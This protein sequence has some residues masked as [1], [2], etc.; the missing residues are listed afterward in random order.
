MINNKKISPK[1]NRIT[2]ISN[3]TKVNLTIGNTSVPAYLG[4]STAA[5][6]LYKQL[7]FKTQVSAG[8]V[9]FCGKFSGLPYLEDE[10]QG[11][12]FAGDICYDPN[13]DWLAV[14]TGGDNAKPHLKEL[15]LGQIAHSEDITKVSQIKG[16]VELMISL[17]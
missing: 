5:K 17:A 9:D 2:E 8:S 6:A 12:W 14:F 4:N 16:T 7:P 3:P 15:F 1:D 10:V 11:G 13:G